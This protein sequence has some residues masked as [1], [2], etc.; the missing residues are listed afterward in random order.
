VERRCKPRPLGLG[1][2]TV[3]YATVNAMPIKP[4]SPRYRH[5]LDAPMERADFFLGNLHNNDTIIFG[6]FVYSI[7]ERDLVC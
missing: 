7:A 5:T 1:Y 3:L 6:Y 4:P 2:L